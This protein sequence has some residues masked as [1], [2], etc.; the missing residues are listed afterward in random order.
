[1]Y[2]QEA[3]QRLNAEIAP[4][5]AEENQCFINGEPNVEVLKNVFHDVM[6]IN[7]SIEVYL[8][9]MNGKIISFY[10]SDSDLQ[11]DHIDLKLVNEFIITGGLIN[12]VITQNV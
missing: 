1:M 7:P 12:P 3:S 5:I 4:H 6:I 8:L 11:L 2:S 9:D 10:P